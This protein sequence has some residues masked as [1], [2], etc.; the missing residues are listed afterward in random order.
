MDGYIRL[1]D[2]QYTSEGDNPTIGLILCAEK[3]EAVAKYSVLNDR[4]QIFASKY[5]LHLPTEQQLQQEIQR[6]LKLIENL[7]G[8]HDEGN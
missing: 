3:N 1:F 2:D 6:E 7:Q 5:M 4:K 8:E